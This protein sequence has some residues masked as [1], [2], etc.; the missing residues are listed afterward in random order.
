MVFRREADGWR[1]IHRH[2]DLQHTTAEVIVTTSGLTI[3]LTRIFHP[4]GT[5]TG[6]ALSAGY[7]MPK[8]KQTLSQISNRN[9]ESS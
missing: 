5:I 9:G 6:L 7:V 3:G 2:A 8:A 4:L 1:I